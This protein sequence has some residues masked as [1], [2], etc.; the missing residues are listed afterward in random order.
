MLVSTSYDIRAHAPARADRL[1]VLLRSWLALTQVLQC[2]QKHGQRLDSE[3]A[4]ET[5][6]TLAT[7]HQWVADLVATGAVI[8]CKLT[9]FDN[10]KRTDLL[11][12]RLSGYIPSLAP[13]RKGAPTKVAEPNVRPR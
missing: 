6:M 5:G 1:P 9:R 12:C 13:G 3:I 7:V 2:L 8:T 10:G 4:K 11:V